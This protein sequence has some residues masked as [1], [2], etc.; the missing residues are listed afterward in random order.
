MVRTLPCYSQAPLYTSCDDDRPRVRRY[1]SF[2]NSC[3]R[4]FTGGL[5]AAVIIVVLGSGLFDFL[6]ERVRQPAARL[7]ASL[8]EYCAGSLWGGFEYPLSRTSAIYQILVGFMMLVLLAT[9][10]GNVAAYSTVSAQ[11]KMSVASLDEAVLNSKSMCAFSAAYLTRVRALYPRINWGEESTSQYLLADK[12]N[13]MSGCDGVLTSMTSLKLWRTKQKYCSLELAQTVFPSAGGW[14][15][16]TH[17][18][19]VQRAIEYGLEVLTSAG[20]LD[21]LQVKYWPKVGCAF[22]TEP[23]SAVA[24]MTF[25]D[26]GGL[27]VVWAVVSIVSVGWAYL[28]NSVQARACACL[29]G[30]WGL[31]VSLFQQARRRKKGGSEGG[32]AGGSIAA[33]FQHQVTDFVRTSV[34]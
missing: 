19:C 28:P 9:Y 27:F 7:N 16:N 1:E 21:E 18:L 12:L 23:Q 33:I 24:Q 22:V 29:A 2:Y 3:L 26:L 20:F 8:Y 11:G 13:D 4:P 31:L 6:I 5:W 14:A 30:L 25:G 32:N 34:F 10:T 15:V 17:S